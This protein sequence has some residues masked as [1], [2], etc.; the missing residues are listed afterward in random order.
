MVSLYPVF[1]FAL[2]F[3]QT[4]VYFGLLK[5]SMKKC[6]WKLSNVCKKGRLV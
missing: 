1:Y 4:I 5:M 3:V 2:V 6:L